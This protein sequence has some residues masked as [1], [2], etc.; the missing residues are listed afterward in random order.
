MKQFL[1]YNYNLKEP[2]VY[3][4]NHIVKIK[5]L[6]N[7]YLLCPVMKP[8]ELEEVYY[9]LNKENISDRFYEINKNI[10]GQ[11]YSYYNDTNYVL[12]TCKKNMQKND[13]PIR[14]TSNISG[15]LVKTNWKELW[16]TK[17][18]NYSK[19]IEKQP[20]SEYNQILY[21]YYNSMAE[22]AI[23]YINDKNV[24][25][26]SQ[27]LTFRVLEE[28]ELNNPL[29]LIVDIEE[30]E[31]G[32]RLRN[33]IIKKDIE[34][35]DIDNILNEYSKDIDLELVYA[36][37]L[38]PNYYYDGLLKNS[39]NNSEFN[40]LITEISNYEQRLKKIYK[41]FSKIQNIKKIDWI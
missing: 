10:N 1:K 35:F 19:I 5:D 24:I 3:T 27:I 25:K 32:E 21:D 29:N 22:T 38:F 14:L 16:I 37:L 39:I 28:E 40:I 2:T 7:R 26:H 33:I 18:D 11:L 30:R 4:V 31:L 13:H 9:L 23:T 20:K 36:R 12:L 6:D 41:N 15:E 34:I 8:K 17:K